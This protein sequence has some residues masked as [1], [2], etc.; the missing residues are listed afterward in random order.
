VPHHP[1]SGEQLAKLHG[2]L[3]LLLVRFAQR[4][5]LELSVVELFVEASERR[6]IVLLEICFETLATHPIVLA[7]EAFVV[8]GVAHD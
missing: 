1:A 6:G 4:D 3:E 7:A 5:L 2:K 8:P